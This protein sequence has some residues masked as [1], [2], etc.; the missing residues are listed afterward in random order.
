V[1]YVAG[2]TGVT[3]RFARYNPVTNTWATLSPMPTPA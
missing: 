2:G 1:V 3:S